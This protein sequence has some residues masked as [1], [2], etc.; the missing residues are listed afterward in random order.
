[1]LLSWPNTRKIDH[2]TVF[3]IGFA[4]RADVGQGPSKLNASLR[5]LINTKGRLRRSFHACDVVRFA[6]TLQGN[7]T[8]DVSDED[9]GQL[10]SR[11]PESN[12]DGRVVAESYKCDA[13]RRIA[14][15]SREYYALTDFRL[16]SD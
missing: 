14:L 6:P 11:Q 9:A 1:M 2:A 5:C 8:F 3:F 15:V 4:F 12:P 16:F 7:N 13:S 10:P